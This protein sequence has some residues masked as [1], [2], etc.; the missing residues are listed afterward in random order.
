MRTMFANITQ[1]FGRRILAVVGVAWAIG[2][3]SAAVAVPIAPGFDDR[4]LA[5]FDSAYATAEIGFTVRMGG[6]DYDRAYVHL[7]GVVT[8]GDSG[9]GDEAQALP[10][11]RETPL[12]A[13]FWVDVDL[14]L[15]DAVTFGQG[16]FDGDAAFAVTWRDLSPYYGGQTERPEN[17]FQLILVDRSSE[18]GPGAFDVF[19][20]YE[21]L[22]F[23]KGAISR[24][25]RAGRSQTYATAG[26]HFG[27]GMDGDYFL[28]PGSNTPDSM[29]DGGAEALSRMGQTPVA[30]VRPNA[31]MQPV[32][33]T[34]GQRTV[35]AVPA[36]PAVWLALSTFAFG[37]LAAGVRR[38]RANV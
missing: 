16:T 30:E 19:Y 11:P 21:K 23:D 5:E 29:L 28:L 9:L 12:L 20:L 27:G 35:A 3:A 1:G 22:E 13:P 32:A 37:G 10:T 34:P 14:R 24:S 7:N 36:P 33:P 17:T 4:S 8:F 15:R 18:A 6:V 2:C 26:G 38:R 25:R 31:M